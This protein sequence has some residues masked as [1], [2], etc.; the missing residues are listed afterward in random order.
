MSDPDLLARLDAPEAEVR[1][2]AATRLVLAGL[3]GGERPQVTATLDSVPTDA[4]VAVARAPDR[5]A[6]LTRLTP[7]LGRALA[8][9]PPGG[10]GRDGPLALLLQAAAE[11]VDLAPALAAVVALLD[12]DAVAARAAGVLRAVA[13]TPSSP[14]DADWALADRLSAPDPVLA[15]AA[16][17]ALATRRLAADDAEGLLGLAHHPDAPVREGCAYALEAAAIAGRPLDAALAS[18]AVALAD[19]AS[20]VAWH[21]VQALDRA[22]RD[23]VD[24]E[25]LV[26]ALR[27][28]RETLTYTADGW[29]FGPERTT[30]DA[31]LDDHLPRAHVAMIEALHLAQR[32]RW[33]ELQAA[34]AAP[35]DLGR[36]ARSAVRAFLASKVP[37]EAR[38]RAASLLA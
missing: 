10:V 12:D 8:H 17:A 31:R 11:G 38:Q 28:A 29:T 20:A 18:L 6:L 9:P 33:A 13:W 36:A 16:A 5:A 25:A 26:P 24:L 32:G 15:H 4:L 34:V 30:G 19:P 23:G 2:D 7:W 37:E 21:A 35:G 14:P 1:R 22:A 27:A 3:R